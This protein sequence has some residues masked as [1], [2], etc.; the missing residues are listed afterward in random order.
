M[1]EYEL[2][3]IEMYFIKKKIAQDYME[4]IS[5]IAVQKGFNLQSAVMDIKI[6]IRESKDNQNTDKS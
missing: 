2:S 5:Q 4:Y 6:I 3:D 1:T